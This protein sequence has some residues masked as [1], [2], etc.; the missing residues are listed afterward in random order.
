MVGNSGFVTKKN[1]EKPE[2]CFKVEKSWM[3]DKK[4]DHNSIMLNRYNAKKGHS[5]L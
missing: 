1:I 3:Q 4:I 5:C 2:V